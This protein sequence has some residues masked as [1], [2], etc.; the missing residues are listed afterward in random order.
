MKNTHASLALVLDR[1]GSMSACLEAAISATNDFLRDQRE[2]EGSADLTITL[3][4]DRIEHPFVATDIEEVPEFDTTS[5]VPR[6]S[7]ALL[8]AIGTTID[9]LGERLAGMPEKDRPG[10]VIVA[11]VTDG[12]ENA[13]RHF[14]WNQVSDRI[15]HQEDVY[16]WRFLF[17][18]AGQ[19][20][21]AQAS[22]MGIQRSC[23]SAFANDH[24]GHAAGSAAYSRKARAIRASAHRRLNKMESMD[25]ARDL[26]KM[27]AE[28][29]Q[30]RRKGESGES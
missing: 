3:F 2:A 15:H 24:T 19:D 14:T 28:E 16:S 6:G 1:S 22:R 11:I 21:I 5:F 20:A 8:D 17:L 26:D 30:K 23:S 4:D 10:A 25:F 27:V 18:A 7:T 13:S 12:M 29:D 9:R